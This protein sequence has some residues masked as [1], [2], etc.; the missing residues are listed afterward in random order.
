MATFHVLASRLAVLILALCLFF[1]S[2]SVAQGRDFR[3]PPP[4]FNP[5]EVK[6]GELRSG[7]T[8]AEVERLLPVKGGV[9]ISRFISDESQL[10]HYF[11][12]Q[13]W[14][15]KVTYDFSGPVRSESGDDRAYDA[16]S[17][18]LIGDVVFEEARLPF[19]FF[20]KTL[21]KPIGVYKK[22]ISNDESAYSISLLNDGLFG[23]KFYR[24]V[25]ARDGKTKQTIEFRS[26]IDLAELADALVFKDENGDGYLDLK[27]VIGFESSKSRWYRTWFF[28]QQS[29]KFQL[30]LAEPVADKIVGASTA[31]E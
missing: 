9:P 18:K 16:P 27:L 20:E 15:V 29:E 25:V 26:P 21:F 22:T 11:L 31:S 28:N 5:W 10:V 23:P 17:N 1:P 2:V 3:R 24:V 6:L 30:V 13:I 12:D 14:S 8:R 7:M 4:E 19:G